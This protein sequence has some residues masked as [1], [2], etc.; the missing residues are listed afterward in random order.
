MNHQKHL[1]IIAENNQRVPF[2]FASYAPHK[3]NN[4]IF[5]LHK[6]YVLP[7]QQKSNTGTQLIQYIINDI[8]VQNATSLQLNVNRMN[9]AIHFY[10]KIG[11]NII[12]E[13]DIDIGHGYF[14]NDYVMEMQL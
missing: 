11:F 8:T 1:F 3:D 9:N 2:G 14:M 13:E 4:K 6:I 12:R 7:H 10:K 5:H